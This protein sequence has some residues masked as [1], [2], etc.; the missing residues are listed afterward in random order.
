MLRAIPFALIFYR[1]IGTS[2]TVQLSFDRLAY[3]FIP[4]LVPEVTS[5]RRMRAM[6]LNFAK[7]GTVRVHK[8]IAA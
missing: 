1:K 5:S 6:Y 8:A 2:T 4:P 3:P 7:Y